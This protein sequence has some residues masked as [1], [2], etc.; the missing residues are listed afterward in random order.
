M[1]KRETTDTIVIHCSQTP[2]GMD[3]DVDKITEWHK[4]RGF[5][6]YKLDGI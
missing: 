6:L 5:V 3:V 4:D 1:N 2:V